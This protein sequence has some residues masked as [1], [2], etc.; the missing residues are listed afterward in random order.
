VTVAGAE[1]TM[2][3]AS[4]TGTFAT[5]KRMLMP[6]RRYRRYASKKRRPIVNDLVVVK[7][8]VVVAPF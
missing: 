6:S 4:T 1:R 7:I 8:V 3:E 2:A 5:A